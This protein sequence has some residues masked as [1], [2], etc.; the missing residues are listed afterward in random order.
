MTIDCCIPQMPGRSTSGFHRLGR[1]HLHQARSFVSNVTGR[2]PVGE[3]ILQRTRTQHSYEDKG[4]GPKT[5]RALKPPPRLPMWQ[6]VPKEARTAFGEVMNGVRNCVR[7]RTETKTNTKISS[8]FLAGRYVPQKRTL[9][10][11]TEHVQRTC[12]RRQRSAHLGVCF[13]RPT[14]K[15]FPLEPVRHAQQRLRLIFAIEAL[16]RRRSETGRSLVDA[17]ARRTARDNF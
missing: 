10:P 9:K 17:F 12:A 6:E 4:A 1:H 8:P 3:L 2:G 11:P 15:A 7:N 5:E 14:V 16:V 13:C